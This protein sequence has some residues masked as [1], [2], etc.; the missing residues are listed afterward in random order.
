MATSKPRAVVVGPKAL[1]KFFADRRS[2]EWDF[3]GNAV[4]VADFWDRTSIED[5]SNP[6]FIP[7]DFQILI[8]VDQ[9]FNPHDQ[10]LRARSSEDDNS[11]ETLIAS[12]AQQDGAVVI[13]AQFAPKIEAQFRAAVRSACQFYNFD[14]DIK[15]WFVPQKNVNRFVDTAIDEYIATS[16]D[17]LNARILSGQDPNEVEPEETVDDTATTI[18]PSVIDEFADEGRLGRVISVTSSK[19]GSGKS[20]VSLLLAT[21]LGYSSKAS[22]KEGLEERPLKVCLMDMDTRDAQIG[23]T[24]GALK[25]NVSQLFV[26]GITK[27]NLH[28]IIIDC[29]R[30]SCDVILA[31]RRPRLAKEISPEFYRDLISALRKEYDIIILDTSVNYLDPLLEKVSY[32]MSDLIVFVTD[33]TKTSVMGMSRWIKEMTSPTEKGGAGIASNKVG[34]VVNSAMKNVNMSVTQISRACMGLPIVS[35]IPNNKQLI[36]HAINI[37]S[38]DKVLL[39]D[40]MRESIG[41][42][43]T[44]IMGNTYK[45]SKNLNI[46]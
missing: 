17:R 2:E 23:F 37:Q 34:I 28:D 4:N 38:M 31:P 16:Q 21:Y 5:E 11:L 39:N 14:P 42:I 9:L 18:T 44:A 35:L 19:G 41:K 45:L 3:V 40:A 25:P 6:D 8:T 33:I 13:I 46:S 7:Q 22:A 24:I 30:L 43:A 26:R 10:E 12:I 32:P 36:T 15:Y 20:T 27:A 1:Y 29:K